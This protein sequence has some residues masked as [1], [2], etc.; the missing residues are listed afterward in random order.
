VRAPLQERSQQSLER[1]LDAAEALIHERGFDEL[2][3][4]ELVQRSRTSVGSFYARFEDKAAL[5]RAVHDRVLGKLEATFEQRVSER[6]PTA[7]LAEAVREEVESFLKLVTRDAAFVR[8]FSA[9]AADPVLL[10]RGARTNRRH[11]AIFRSALM[12]HVGEITHADPE[13]AI[14]FAYGVHQSAATALSWMLRSP[15]PP[16]SPTDTAVELTRMLLGY[17]QFG[18]P[19]APQAS[20]K[21]KPRPRRKA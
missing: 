12:A 5:L 7:S 21:P 2:T 14:R 1:M 17:L 3:V 19:P 9:F 15:E 6:A 10:A 16:I 20:I 18:V 11:F 8:A 4:S 13:R